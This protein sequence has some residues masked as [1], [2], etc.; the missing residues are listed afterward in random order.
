MAVGMSS[1]WGLREQA[2]DGALRAGGGRTG[3][4]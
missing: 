4:W 3:T 2:L 1:R